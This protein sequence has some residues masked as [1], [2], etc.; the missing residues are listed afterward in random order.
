[1]TE[2]PTYKEL[3]QRITLLEN[4][5]AQRER[6][7]EI[8]D[9]LFKISNAV[10]MTSNLDELYRTIH[11]ALSPVIDTTNFYISLYDK[12]EDRVTF[13]Y[14]V[15]TVDACYPPVIEVSKTSSLTAEVIR[16]GRPL[17]VTKAEILTRRAESS[18]KIPAC[19]PSEIWLGVP[20]KTRDEIIGVMVVQSY[21]D[22]KCYDQTDMNLMVS[23]AD[24]VALAVERKQAEDALQRAHDEL[25]Q[26][27][28]ERT[29]SLRKSEA[30]LRTLVQT[31]PDLIWLKDT[32]GVYLDC[33]PMF[34]RLFGAAKKNIIGKTDYDFVDR[35]LADFFREHD[36][37][38]IA[39]GMPSRN[40]EWLTFADGGYR[41][42][43]DTI[44]TPMLD[45][46]GKLMGVLGIAHDLTERKRAEEEKA[47][48]EAQLQQAQKMEFIGS[49]AGGIAHDLNNILFPISG[50]SELLLNDM[51]PDIPERGSLEQI[52]KAAQ[53]GS[54]LVKQ[55]LAFSRQTNLQKLPIRIQP[56]LKEA[57][58][59]ARAAIPKKI[60]ITSHI[61]ADCGM[62]SADPTQVHQVL[63]N[64]ITNAFH[65]VEVN[66][67]SIHVEL[68]APATGWNDRR[69]HPAF[70]EKEERYDNSM[71]GDLL[72]G[73]YACIAI[74]DT[75]TGIDQ[76][77]IDRIFEP[78]F[79]TKKLGK[80]TGLGLSVVHGIVKAHGGD[81][82][83]YSE[84]G[85]GTTF[86]VYLPLLQAPKE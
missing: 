68:K 63:M 50:L 76:A 23:V 65:A 28:K 80:G 86:N 11:L 53:R 83:V 64:L 17:C 45:A 56:I 25:E 30:R 29:E 60:E 3:E 47:K 72:A 66:G 41:A 74:S 31:I 82:R 1:M 71:P 59:L 8:N 5:S 32:D 42:L 77:L 39:A 24:Q 49:L 34:E 75:G 52:Y 84:A 73:E 7:E 36:R 51:P 16:T 69:F 38:A 43:F 70:N 10:N 13:P 26:R 9:T 15:D 48:L 4:E 18:L 54:D 79:T 81:I 35:E 12:T 22:P 27:V 62:V 85:K 21:L 14:C 33:N 44:K 2:K 61:H 20:L 67:G 57:L 6:F 58:I 78:Y 19:T 55:I 37:K 40:E 46:E